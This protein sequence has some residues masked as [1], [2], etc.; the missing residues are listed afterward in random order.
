MDVDVDRVRREYPIEDLLFKMGLAKRQGR[1]DCPIPGCTSE[2]GKAPTFTVRG[3]FFFC[4]R[5]KSK[6]DVIGLVMQTQQLPFRD[7]VRY[8]TG[9]DIERKT[10][11]ASTLIEIKGLTRLAFRRA[12]QAFWDVGFQIDRLIEDRRD[13]KTAQALAQ[14]NMLFIADAD[15]FEK[16]RTAEKEADEWFAANDEI[17]LI[18]YEGFK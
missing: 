17:D 12:R 14:W 3:D 10:G 11:T 9:E 6:G 13:A 16:V 8:V 18:V 5:C 1:Y 15:Y 7:A 2:H 4:H